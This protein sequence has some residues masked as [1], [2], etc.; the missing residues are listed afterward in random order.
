MSIKNSTNTPV[1]KH[2]I[3]IIDTTLRDGEQAPGV[4]FSVEEK[5]HLAMLLAELGVDEL[6]VGSPATS[7]EEREAIRR[8]TSLGLPC[9][10]SVWCRACHED[11]EMAAYCDVDTV[12][13]SLP[14]SD[15]LL[16]AMD[17]DRRWV[18]KQLE[19]CMNWSTSM[20]ERT[21]VG[22]QDASRADI[23]FLMQLACAADA[24]GATR[25]R[26]SDTVGILNPSSTK[27]LINNVK[28][29]V[30][31]NALIDE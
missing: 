17:K 11:L 10:T 26:I 21:S 29:L 24:L 12:H 23:D 25:V 30:V 13:I 9:R 28:K 1:R 18:W 3:K 4:A 31:C 27:T 8:I 5:V 7:E 14:T 16:D 2:Q 6:E 20:F 22:L 19:N 15:I